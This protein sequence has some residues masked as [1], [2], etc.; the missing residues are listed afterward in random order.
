MP[1]SD[2][3]TEFCSKTMYRRPASMVSP[4]LCTYRFIIC[5]K[6]VFS[7]IQANVGLPGLVV[8]VTD[9]RILVGIFF[10]FDTDFFQTPS[11]AEPTVL[12]SSS[13]D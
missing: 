11:L 1:Q 2:L 8:H 13:C 12:C 4:L 6:A 7:G 10:S 5:L 3:G 9:G